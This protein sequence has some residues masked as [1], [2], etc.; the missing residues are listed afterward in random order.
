METLPI[1][2]DVYDRL[3]A[4]DWA[5][6][7]KNLLG[8]AIWLAR[9]NYGW[10]HS[11][12]DQLPKGMKFE[13]IVQLVILKTIDGRRRWDPAKGPLEPWLKDQIRSELDELYKSAANRREVYSAAVYENDGV[14]T[15]QARQGG[16]A[17]MQVPY[18]PSAEEEAIKREEEATAGKLLGAIYEK[19]AGQPELEDIISALMGGCEPKPQALADA[20]DVQVTEINNRQKRLKRRA[21]EARREQSNG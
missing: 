14:E 21:K 5:E 16:A 9:R 8:F 13:D 11:T 12:S 6:I 17:G 2:K 20:L 7:G 10:W 3:Q 1:R 15:L 4:A 19:I 18:A